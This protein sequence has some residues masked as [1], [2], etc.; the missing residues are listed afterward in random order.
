[1]VT[2]ARQ[3]IRN[4]VTN[5]VRYGGPTIRMSFESD[6][7]QVAMHVEDDGA[8]V[9]E[10]LRDAIFEPYRQAHDDPRAVPSSIGLGLAVSRQLAELMGGS[11]DYSRGGAWNRFSLRLP[12]VDG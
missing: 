12:A 3:I 10:P 1:M 7:D 2:Y 11:L 6:G 9:P 5:A 8:P 4:L